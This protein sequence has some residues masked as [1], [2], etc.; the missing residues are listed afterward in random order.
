[1][2]RELSDGEI[3]A[4]RAEVRAWMKSRP[5]VTA[6]GIAQFTVLSEHTVRAWIA[7]SFPGGREVV[8]GILAAV[9]RARAATSWRLA[10]V[11]P[12]C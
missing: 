9:R 3:N 2:K 7:G 5:D 10:P 4:A 6:T 11:N 12:C 1:M 8:G